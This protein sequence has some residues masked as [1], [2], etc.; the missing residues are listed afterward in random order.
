VLLFEMMCGYPAFWAD[1]PLGIYEKILGGRVHF[2]EHVHPVARDLIRRLLQANLTRRL[3]N[4]KGGTRDIM[5]HAWFEGVDWDLVRRRM[6]PVRGALVHP[7]RPL[8]GRVQT[9]P[10]HAPRA[11]RGRLLAL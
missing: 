2:P 4:L 9:G 10:Y 7:K 6:I 8:T 5:A 3:G 1:N 11:E